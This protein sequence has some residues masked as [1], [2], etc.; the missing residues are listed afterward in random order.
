MASGADRRVIGFGDD[1]GEAVMRW[2][3]LALLGVGASLSA[4]ED[5]KPV[6]PPAPTPAPAA[7]RVPA[8]APLA[9]A[10]SELTLA[11]QPIYGP[12]RAVTP[13]H[14]LALLEAGVPLPETDPGVAAFSH[15]LGQLTARYVEDAGRIAEVTSSVCRQIRAKNQPASPAEVLEG[16]LNWRRPA[17]ARPGVPRRYSDYARRYL[18][19]RVTEGK[20][21]KAALATLNPPPPPP[22]PRPR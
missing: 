8:V 19:L 16:A 4:A 6:P 3:S 21:H 18:A 5:P 12:L 22:T 10:V 11:P 9:P 15:V 17:G 20:D 7:V 2:V 1:V 14:R 13:A